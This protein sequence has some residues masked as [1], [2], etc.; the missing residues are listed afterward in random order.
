LALG[1]DPTTPVS[2]TAAAASTTS[3]CYAQ[4]SA[5]VAEIPVL[6]LIA[7]MAD[8]LGW[9]ARFTLI[10]ILTIYLVY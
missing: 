10:I 3:I 9:L 5:A 6:L 7:P 2:A 1:L 4:F 8:N